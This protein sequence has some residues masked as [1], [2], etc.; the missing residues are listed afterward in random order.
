MQALNWLASQLAWE[1]QLG[2]LRNG[3][4]RAPVGRAAEVADTAAKAA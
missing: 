4:H 3:G 1:R 2:A